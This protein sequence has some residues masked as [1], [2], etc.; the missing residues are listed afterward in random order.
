MGAAGSAGAPAAGCASRGPAGRRRCTRSRPAP[1]PAGS[2]SPSL[3]V[4]SASAET[5]GAHLGRSPA[6]GPEV[7]CFTKHGALVRS[8]RHAPPC[9]ATAAQQAAPAHRLP[10]RSQPAWHGRSDTMHQCLAP[11]CRLQRVASYLVAVVVLCPALRL[12][13]RGQRRRT[14]GRAAECVIAAA[15]ASEAQATLSASPSAYSTA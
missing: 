10:S 15:P 7:C 4:L 2:W 3:A 12:R 9:A 5:S 13:R 8:A 14:L 11:V 1:R 6:A